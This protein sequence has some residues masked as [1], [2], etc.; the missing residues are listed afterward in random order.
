MKRKLQTPFSQRQYMLSDHFEIYYYNDTHFSGVAPHSHDYYEFYFFLEGDISMNIDGYIH[1]LQ[2]GDVILIPP[3]IP[4]HAVS[5][6]S[7]VPYRRFVF[8]VQV[9]YVRQLHEVSSCYTYIL[10]L[11]EEKKRHLFRYDTISF[12]TLQ[13]K[14]FRLIEENFSSY[15]G[16]D[17]TVA[18]CAN[19]LLLYLN[20]TVYEM[21]HPQNSREE[22]HLYKNLLHYI[23]GHLEEELSLEQIAQDFY[24]SKYH[25]AHIFKEN[26]GISLHQYITKKRLAKCRDSI[27][28]GTGISKAFSLYGFKDYS[29]FFRAFKKEYGIS[30]KEYRELH[31]P[32]T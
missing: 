13:A 12:H 18:L 29:S 26:M 15:Y 16:K 4:H 30:P 32:T 19:D 3:G 9:D 2:S 5:H 14:I 28:S 22:Q 23:E 17:A 10:R 31:T 8:W 1:N 7:D 11:A 20:R 25:I 6:N 27:L 24:V 21:E